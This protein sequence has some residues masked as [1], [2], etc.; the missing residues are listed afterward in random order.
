MPLNPLNFNQLLHSPDNS[1]LSNMFKNYYEGMEMAQTPQRL[2]QERLQ[3]DLKNQISGVEAEYAQPKAQAG[4]QKQQQ[5][6]ELYPQIKREEMDLSKAH[7]RSYGA[8]VDYK[9]AQAEEINQRLSQSRGMSDLPDNGVP[10]SM[11]GA[12]E[13]LA[14]SKEV[15]QQQKLAQG[16]MK[17]NKIAYELRK[18]MEDHP[19]LADEFSSAFALAG[20]KPSFLAKTKRNLFANKKDL[21]AYEKFLKLSN[22]L[23]LQQGDALGKNFTDT[24][25]TLLAQSK[26]NPN[27]TDEANKYLI[28]KIISETAPA[29]RYHQALENSRRGRYVP[30]LNMEAYRDNSEVEGLS[31]DLQK[32]I[33]MTKD[34]ESKDKSFSQMTPEELI[35]AYN[36]G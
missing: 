4:L 14:A 24:K 5:E 9:N 22:D 21:G 28:D 26:P 7:R 11:M 13:K 18:I 32:G 23:I 1:G 25:A 17:V 2:A 3:A 16:Q 36:N 20:D 8:D 10:Y 35:E 30:Q 33:G 34:S 6:N 31:V 12:N 27:N 15:T 29:K 19:K